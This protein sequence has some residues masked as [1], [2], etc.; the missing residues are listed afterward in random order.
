M[1]H[2]VLLALLPSDTSTKQIESRVT[3]LLAPYSEEHEVAPYKEK[4]WCVGREAIS[5]ARKHANEVADLGPV[6]EMFDA[7]IKEAL[8]G[9]ERLERI[10]KALDYDPMGSTLSEEDQEYAYHGAR[11][12]VSKAK[13]HDR[14]WAVAIAKLEG[15]EAEFLAERKD[16]DQA[17]AECDECRGSGETQT[18]SN[19]QGYWDW[20]C[21]GGRWN[22]MLLG[23]EYNAYEDERNYQSCRMCQGTGKRDD[24]LGR[25]QRLLHPGYS[26]N[27][28]SGTGREMKFPSKQ[29][30]P[31]IGGNWRRVSEIPKSAQIPFAVV[32]PDGEWHQKGEM[33]MFGISR[34]EM[35]EEDWDVKLQSIYGDYHDHIAVV[36]DCHT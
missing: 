22:G 8:K 14:R 10:R 18:T 30:E 34:D 23:D 32:T 1:S 7:E 13:D 35:P 11:N 20:W 27:V 25:Q 33:L 26:C 6:R 12:E 15:A 21:I 17:D 4:C 24:E 19:P 28:C 31:P 16:R 3:K 2:F 36:V 9:N 29:P 5:A